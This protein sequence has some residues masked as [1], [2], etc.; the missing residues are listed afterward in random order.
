MDHDPIFKEFTQFLSSF[1]SYIVHRLKRAGFNF[2]KIKDVVVDALLAR[3]GANT[4]FFIHASIVV[5]AVSVLAGGGVFS[6]TSVVSGSFPGVPV[7]P[8]VAGAST[9]NQDSGVISSSIT[10]VT[11]ISD[12]P[13]DKILDYEV[14]VGD[15]VSS[16]AEEYGVSESTIQWANDLSSTS[17]LKQGQKLKILPVSGVS[18]KVASGDT[19]YSVAKKYQANAQAII[20]FPFNDVGNDFQLSTGSVLIVPDGAPPEKPKPAPTQYLAS[21]QNV[22]IDNLGSSQFIWPANG[23]ISQ[24]FSWY[25]PGIDISNL[26]GGPIRASDSG[27]VTMAGWPDNYGYGNRVIVDHGNGFTTL[28]AHMSSIYVSPGQRVSKGDVLGAMGSTGRSTGVHV[29]LEIRKNGGALNPLS[30]LG[31]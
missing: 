13:R 10:P 11:I 19:I 7:N 27:T 30:L 12:K 14:K 5:L 28:Y 24:Y 18:H 22:P 8:L 3:R 6:S 23:G 21:G 15:T 31:K 2:E 16:I 4:S 20:D 25:H 17:Q 9:N 1:S 26:G 29:H